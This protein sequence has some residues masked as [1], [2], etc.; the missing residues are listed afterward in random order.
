M[1]TPNEAPAREGDITP[2]TAF[3][4]IPAQDAVTTRP[5]A[6]RGDDDLMSQPVKPS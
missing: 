6:A 3:T 4:P 2:N 1:S 5:P